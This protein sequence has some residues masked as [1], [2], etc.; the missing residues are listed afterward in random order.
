MALLCFFVVYLKI[1]TNYDIVYTK[2]KIKG[3]KYGKL[4]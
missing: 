1:D 3:N 4:Y 2:E